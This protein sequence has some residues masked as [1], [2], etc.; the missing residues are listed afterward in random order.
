MAQVDPSYLNIF[1]WHV[2]RSGHQWKC[3]LGCVNDILGSYMLPNIWKGTIEVG[4]NNWVRQ[5]WFNENHLTKTTGCCIYCIYSRI[6]KKLPRIRTVMFT[7]HEDGVANRRHNRIYGKSPKNDDT[8]LQN[9]LVKMD[10]F[11]Q[12]PFQRLFQPLHSKLIPNVC[13]SVW[14]PLHK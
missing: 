10:I 3:F 4:V 1:F 12:N 13:Q 7:P 14:N 2:H 6:R 5:K 8:D 11:T 9:L